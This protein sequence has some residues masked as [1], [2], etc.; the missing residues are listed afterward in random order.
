MKLFIDLIKRSLPLAI[1]LGG[2]VAHG[3]ALPAC[4]AALP[5][6]LNAGL[7]PL[8]FANFQTLLAPNNERVVF[9]HATESADPRVLYSVR[10]TGGAPV[11]LSVPTIDRIYDVDISPDSTRVVYS[12]SEPGSSARHL[13]SVPIAGP[14]SANIRLADEAPTRALIS[15]DSR[16]VVF[17]PAAGDR[18]RVVPIEGPANAGARLTAPMVAGGQMGAFKIT[19]DSRSVIYHA[20]QE[21]DG[22][23]E[24]FRVPLTLSPQP[25]PPT[26]KLNGPLPDGGDVVSFQVP[27]IDGPIVYL[28]DQITNNVNELFSV[29]AGG[30]GRVRLNATVPSG[31]QISD[32]GCLGSGCFGWFIAPG[33]KRVVFELEGFPPG[34]FDRQL[35]S[36]PI[37]GGTPVRLDADF[38]LTEVI[39]YLISPDGN[40]ITYSMGDGETNDKAT[41]SVPVVGP[42]SAGVQ[43]TETSEQGDLVAF[44]ADS[45]RVLWMPPNISPAQF[46]S[47]P[48]AGPLSQAVEIS[49][50]EDPRFLSVSSA[51][52]QRV[53]Y[54]A[55][56]PGQSKLDVF[57][58]PQAGNG[59][60][61]NL[62]GSIGDRGLFIGQL[63]MSNNGAYVVYA[64]ETADGHFN[65][66]A[67]GVLQ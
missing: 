46:M 32:T 6:K 42:A 7:G 33:G 17:R 65:L 43:V 47:T 49:G 8:A 59:T 31:M 64:A 40:R 27:S 20:D 54:S 38:S 21:T 14:A 22:V 53:I 45:S 11:R 9:V 2:G 26:V 34:G 15:P 12:A 29:R 25:D 48:I 30:A 51:S 37:A 44:T 62:S 63:F 16:K 66:W 67:S 58:V 18:L 36:V 5:C 24:L 35:H 19:A 41:F 60:R 57:S 13:F 39:A 50:N 52:R 28:A 23:F 3:Q 10:F 56:A 1:V 61:F 55:Q 4:V